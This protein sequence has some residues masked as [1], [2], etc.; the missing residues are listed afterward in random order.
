[1]VVCSAVSAQGFLSFE[2]TQL[3]I[4]KLVNEYGLD[5]NQVE[6]W[7]ARGK[8][9]ETSVS[10]AAAP[11]EQTKSYAEYRPMFLSWHVIWQGRRFASKYHD[12]LLHS[13]QQYGVPGN[14]V[15]AI[16]GIES[17]YGFTKGKHRTFDALGSLAVTEGRRADYFMREWV[18]FIAMLHQQG[19]DPLDMKG[20][21]AG[22]TGYSQ[23]MPS[24]YEAYA[25]DLD[26]DGD[27][28]IWNDPIDSIGSVANYLKENGWKAGQPV[29]SKATVAEL[30]PGLSINTFSRD[31]KMPQILAAGWKIEA[32]FDT[33]WY[34]FPVRLETDEGPQYWLGYRNFWSISRYNRSISYAM[35]VYQLAEA[36]A[37]SDS[38]EESEN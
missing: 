35:A 12:Q 4:D 18:K 16:I 20:S 22:A 6:E 33:D 32:P 27:I 21:Y 15:V 26:Q 14:I 19:M 8:Y 34:V 29:L 24:S 13:E 25:V 36:I 23:F 3:A 30:E 38:G 11:V 5:K 10:N 2:R 37:E 7:M 9:H 17:R 31:R 1:M 28:D